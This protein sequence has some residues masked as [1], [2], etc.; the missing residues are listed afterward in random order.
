MKKRKLH[1]ELL[2]RSPWIFDGEMMIMVMM[3][4]MVMMVVMVVI[5]RMMMPKRKTRKKC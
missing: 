3:V 4:M 5:T 1:S 2:R